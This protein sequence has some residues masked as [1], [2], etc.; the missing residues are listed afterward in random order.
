MGLC[1][2]GVSGL[3]E[4][5]GKMWRIQRRKEKTKPQLIETDGDVTQAWA[6]CS[7][8]GSFL[9]SLGI[10]AGIWGSFAPHPRMVPTKG[11]RALL[12]FAPQEAT[13]GASLGFWVQTQQHVP[14][15]KVNL[16][17]LLVHRIRKVDPA[18]LRMPPLAPF[19]LRSV[20]QGWHQWGDAG[21]AISGSPPCFCSL[22]PRHNCTDV[23]PGGTSRSPG[24]SELPPGEVQDRS[25]QEGEPLVPLRS[26]R[27]VS[28]QAGYPLVV[29]GELP[30]P[31]GAQ[32]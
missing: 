20:P 9:E 25:G 10:G 18:G 22:T 26:C 6:M 7:V 30:S 28:P 3:L 17:R 1:L 21:A 5:W 19:P 15:W 8:C 2:V 14:S 11:E 27:G 12:C 32:Q 4:V 24:P 29:A 13:L 16:P 31:T 23:V